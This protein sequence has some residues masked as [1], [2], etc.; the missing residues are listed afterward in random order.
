MDWFVK[1]SQEFIV[2]SLWRRKGIRRGWTREG[3]QPSNLSLMVSVKKKKE[4]ITVTLRLRVIIWLI[5][6]V[7]FQTGCRDWLPRNLSGGTLSGAWRLPLAA[8]AF[9]EKWNRGSNLSAKRKRRTHP[10]Q[11]LWCKMRLLVFFF[12]LSFF[13]PSFI[14]PALAVLR[15]VLF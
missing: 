5:H 15:L 8:V 12:F 10:R 7:P 9:R 6:R 13:H 14:A 3:K 11:L 2:K 1:K 4:M